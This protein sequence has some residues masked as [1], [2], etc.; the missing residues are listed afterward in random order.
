MVSSVCRGSYPS[1]TPHASPSRKPN[2]DPQK[3][4]FSP[5]QVETSV[6]YDLP[7]HIYPPKGSQPILMIHPGYMSAVRARSR[8]VVTPSPTAMVATSG[9]ARPLAPLQL[10][11]QQQQ[12]QQ[13][14]PQQQQQVA[15]ARSTRATQSRP[16]CMC[17]NP[18]CN[19]SS[20]KSVTVQSARNVQNVQSQSAIRSVQ[21]QSGAR[22]AQSQSVSRI[23]QNQSATRNVPNQSVPRSVQSQSARSVQSAREG[24]MVGLPSRN[25]VVL[26]QQQQQQQPQQPQQPPPPA[27][28][29]QSQQLVWGNGGRCT[30]PCCNPKAAA[31]APPQ[32]EFVAPGLPPSLLARTP[33]RGT[34]GGSPKL[35]AAR[36]RRGLS[37]A[38]SVNLPDYLGSS[39]PARLTGGAVHV[40][41]RPRALSTS[42]GALAA[43]PAP[44]MAH[45]HMG[46]GA[47][48][49]TS[50]DLARTDP[51]TP[52]SLMPVQQQQQQQQQQAQQQQQQQQQP[53]QAHQPMQQAP[54]GSTSSLLYTVGLS[55]DSGCSVGTE[56]AGGEWA[57]DRT[58]GLV[59]SGF[60]TPVDLTDDF[61]T[62]TLNLS[63]GSW[64]EPSLPLPS[65]MTSTSSSSS[66]SVHTSSLLPGTTHTSSLLPGAAHA[67][68]YLPQPLWNLAY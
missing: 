22:N 18:N 19:S 61:V 14:V 23:I 30:G 50:L 36:T 68:H 51:V 13:Q 67:H 29:Q 64:K 6:E 8:A 28:Q 58:R 7:A 1:M 15:S 2:I 33:T 60:C 37:V 55:R 54:V 5:L 4:Y 48:L 25:E 53:Q 35:R 21:N 56:T 49:T 43:T 3:D 34:A 62:D 47:S 65:S 59:D 40:H 32:A 16:W 17:G 26:L 41:P 10:A 46:M 42:M 52:R 44:S 31:M 27:P 63:G 24:S 11:Q 20:V 39:R 38:S 57:S 9:A 45:Q 66:S 12:P